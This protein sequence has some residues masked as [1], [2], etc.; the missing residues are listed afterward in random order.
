M[1]IFFLITNSKF[2]RPNVFFWCNIDVYIRHKNKIEVM[3]NIKYRM[4]CYKMQG[5][6]NRIYIRIH[7]NKLK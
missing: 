6:S 1:I 7:S 4:H 3:H 2:N 5:V